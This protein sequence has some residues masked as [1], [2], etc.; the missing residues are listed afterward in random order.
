MPKKLSSRQLAVCP[1]APGLLGPGC[2]LF[3]EASGCSGTIRGLSSEGAWS[4]TAP[5]LG[6]Q[7]QEG[8]DCFPRSLG[9][10]RGVGPSGTSLKV[11]ASSVILSW[12]GAGSG[13]EQEL[14]ILGERMVTKGV[15][16]SPRAENAPGNVPLINMDEAPQ[17]LPLTTMASCSFLLVP[18][19]R[20][21]LIG[22]GEGARRGRG[23]EGRVFWWSGP[24]EQLPAPL[25]CRGHVATCSRLASWQRFLRVVQQPGSQ[26]GEG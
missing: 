15:S 1:P 12:L 6:C 3:Q 17:G 13:Q 16:V 19:P 4:I 25:L 18:A 2:L 22:E 8:W 23:Q 7:I 10:L 21:A 24:S 20:T 11:S 9:S 5:Q 14:A 26:R